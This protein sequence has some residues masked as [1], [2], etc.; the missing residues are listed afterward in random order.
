MPDEPVIANLMLENRMRMREKKIAVNSEGSSR[1]FFGTRKLPR[2][3]SLT[4]E[5]SFISEV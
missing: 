3:G 4:P 5:R 2:E 1:N